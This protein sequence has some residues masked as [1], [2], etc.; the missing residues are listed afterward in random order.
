[1]THNGLDAKRPDHRPGRNDCADSAQLE[2]AASTSKNTLVLGLGAG[3]TEAVLVLSRHKDATFRIRLLVEV[4]CRSLG[5]ACHDNIARSGRADG[6][7]PPS[8]PRATFS[9][10]LHRSIRSYNMRL[11]CGP[12]T[13]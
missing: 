12:K 3:D 11:S 2:R 1:M 7:N 4:D 8:D 10:M 6:S 9:F 5:S 13:S